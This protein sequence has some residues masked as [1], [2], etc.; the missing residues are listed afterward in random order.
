MRYL[1]DTHTLLWYVENNS[2]LPQ[3]IKHLIDD[4]ANIVIVSVAT[5]WELGIKVGLG[6]LDLLLTTDEM[7][8]KVVEKGF[9]LLPISLHHIKV[10]QTLPHHHRDPFDRMLIAQADVESCTVLTR[11]EMF[12]AYTVPV[13]W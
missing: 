9:E 8:Q 3:K 10:I 7:A 4:P 6:K 12:D 13:L 11:D 1:L 5:F 2:Q